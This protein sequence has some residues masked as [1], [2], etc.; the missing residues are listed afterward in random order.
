[1]LRLYIFSLTIYKHNIYFQLHKDLLEYFVVYR[2][3]SNAIVM[4]VM[5]L[6]VGFQSFPVHLFANHIHSSLY[7]CIHLNLPKMVIVKDGGFT[8]DT[9]TLFKPN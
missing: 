5:R 3:K 4:C 8:S 2:F 9:P 7:Q 6:S 1:M